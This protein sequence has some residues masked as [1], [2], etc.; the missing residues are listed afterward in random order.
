M[1]VPH[2]V[3]ANNQ[4]HISGFVSSYIKVLFQLLLAGGS[5]QAKLV[6]VDVL[7]D[8]RRCLFMQEIS[9]RA[10]QSACLRYAAGTQRS[11]FRAK[12]Y[13]CQW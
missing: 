13:C 5:T 12:S 11:A 7:G 6:I 2:P 1:W 9:D 8:L 10:E 3:T 4:G